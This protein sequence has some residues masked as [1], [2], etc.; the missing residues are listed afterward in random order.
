[1]DSVTRRIQGH[2]REHETP[3]HPRLRSAR[4]AYVGVDVQVLGEHVPAKFLIDTGADFTTLGPE[5]ALAALGWS[6]LELD[7]A[8]PA[9]RLDLMGVGAGDA[10][11]T[12]RDAM[13]TFTADNGEK[14]TMSVA[15]AIARPDPATP[16]AHGNWLMPSLLGR[17]VL[18]HFDLRLSYHPPSVVLE[19]ASLNG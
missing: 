16:A 15:L 8:D 6:Y 2:F 7:F 9:T 5:D 1:M 3:P 4:A 12:I 14:M 13:L 10:S 18:Q 19:E 11:A 17:D